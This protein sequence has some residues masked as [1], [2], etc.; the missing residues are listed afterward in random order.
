M[1][2]PQ[3]RLDLN[4]GSTVKESVADFTIM[5]VIYFLRMAV[6]EDKKYAAEFL[7]SEPQLIA[8]LIAL[9]QANLARSFVPA[10]PA[11]SSATSSSTAS[12]PTANATIFPS[13]ESS[14]SAPV[15]EPVEVDLNKLDAII[16]VRVSGTRVW[17]YHIADPTVVLRAMQ[18]NRRA[19]TETRVARLGGVGGFNFLDVAGRKEIIVALD[20]VRQEFQASGRKAQ[21]RVLHAPQAPSTTAVD[22]STGNEA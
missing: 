15:S 7:N 18:T 8:E 4:F 1:P 6:I 16:G 14:E 12:V 5:D 10:P 22:A 2:F 21:R 9:F 20:Q 11:S 13:G 3:F 19:T 17:F